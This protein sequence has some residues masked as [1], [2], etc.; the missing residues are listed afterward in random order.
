LRV[1]I[2]TVVPRGAASQCLPALCERPSI[3]VALV[4]V[5][6]GVVANRRKRLVRKLRKVRRIGLLGVATGLYLRTW[7]PESLPEDVRVVAGRRGIPVEEVPRMNCERTRTL[8]RAA[9]A[10]L[11]L[12]LGTPLIHSSV[13]SIPAHG[14]LNVHGDV[15]PAFRGGMSVIWPIYEGVREAGFT[16]HRID[17]GIDTGSILHV[18]R[19]P[20]DL[21]PT[22]R[23]T[24]V[25]TIGEIQR[26]VPERLAGVLERFPELAARAAEQRQEQGRTYT[27]PSFWQFL[28]MV[29]Q[30]RRWW[31]ESRGR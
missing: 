3:D 26:R 31:R 24:Y 20:I 21:R 19:F 6:Q 1:V 2:L 9:G 15:L 10:D 12:T 22:L 17:S 8:L 18:E 11:G 28:R 27:T 14:M 23:E 5:G 4:I 7:Q 30:H 16:I 13:F 25:A 29:R